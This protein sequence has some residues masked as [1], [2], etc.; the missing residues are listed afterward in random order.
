MIC[1]RRNVAKYSPD[2]TADLPV[3]QTI[4]HK[5]DNYKTKERKIN[6]SLF[7]GAYPY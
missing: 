3:A 2:F 1:S 7:G 5:K 4:S 6:Q